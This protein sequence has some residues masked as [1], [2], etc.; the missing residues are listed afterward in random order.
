MKKKTEKVCTCGRIITDPK[1]KTGLCPKCAKIAGDGVAVAGF[2]GLL[3]LGKKYGPK[4]IK[5]I[6]NII[7]NLKK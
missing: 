7:K 3:L 6:G 2:A 5:G 4:A 1:N